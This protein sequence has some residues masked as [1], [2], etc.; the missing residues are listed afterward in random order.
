M[1]SEDQSLSS[2]EQQVP[3]NDGVLR[4]IGGGGVLLLLVLI[5]IG[6]W[7]GVQHSPETAL[8]NAEGTPP[9][10]VSTDGYIG[11]Q[12]CQTCHQHE[13]ATWHDSYHRTMT[14]L[15][16]PTTVVGDFSGIELESHGRKFRVNRDKETAWI[17]SKAAGDSETVRRDVVLCT[18][19]HHMQAY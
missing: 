1:D 2:Q 5:I 9:V 7:L 19:S 11:S 16:S 14:Q 12:K 18:G 4:W 8:T 10:A 17:E 3:P 13:H 6:L 15:P